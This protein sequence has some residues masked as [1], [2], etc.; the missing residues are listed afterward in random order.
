MPTQ[1]PAPQGH[2]IVGDVFTSPKIKNGKVKCLAVKTCYSGGSDGHDPYPDGWT[3]R[4]IELPKNATDSQN[5]I[6][7]LL[8]KKT[9]S[10]YQSGCFTDSCMIEPKDTTRIGRMKET[11]TWA[12]VK[13]PDKKGK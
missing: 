8:E 11:R 10:F 7:Q 1:S 5:S 13:F 2:L 3:V 4:Y 12:W 9:K 6:V